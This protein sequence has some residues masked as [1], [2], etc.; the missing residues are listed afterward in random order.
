MPSGGVWCLGVADVGHVST[1]IGWHS[2]MAPKWAIAFWIIRHFLKLIFLGV[3]EHR[4][5]SFLAQVPAVWVAPASVVRSRPAVS[6]GL[7]IQ[8]SQHLLKCCQE[9]TL[10]YA[11]RRPWLGAHECSEVW[12]GSAQ[13]T[14]GRCGDM[15]LKPPSREDLLPSSRG[16]V[17]RQLSVGSFPVLA[18]PQ[19]QTAAFFEVMSFLGGTDPLTERVWV[20]LA[21]CGPHLL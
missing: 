19:L 1:M 7:R 14:C 12:G 3:L 10:P 9:P 15:T 6:V 17:S 8:R 4:N 11:T 13:S 20:V 5:F 18:L 21:Q 2:Y 16:V